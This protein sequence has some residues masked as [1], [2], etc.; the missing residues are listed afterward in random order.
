MTQREISIIQLAA[1]RASGATVLIRL[2]V[3]LIFVGEGVLKFVRPESLGSGRFVKAGIPAGAFFANLDGAFE[4]G[5]GLLILAG[6]LV[7]LATL[8]MIVDMIGA[9]GITKVP[10]LWGAAPLYPKEGGFWDFFHEGRLEIAM[11]CGSVFLLIA[12]AGTYSLD[13]RLGRRASV[14]HAANAPA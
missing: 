14:P 6:L 12:G 8:P 13:A 9:L 11:L 10:L 1:T 3:G 7:R 4:I 5:C 2:Y